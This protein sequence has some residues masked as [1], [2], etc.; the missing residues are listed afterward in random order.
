MLRIYFYKVKK[1]TKSGLLVK[2]W[3]KLQ[4]AEKRIKLL[5]LRELSCKT[6]F[7][8]IIRIS[9]DLSLCHKL[10]FSNPQSL[11]PNVVD[12]INLKL[13]ILLNNYNNISKVYIGLQ[14]FRDRKFI[15]WKRLNS[16]E[17]KKCQDGFSNPNFL[18]VLYEENCL[19]SKRYF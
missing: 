14:W 18:N 8:R 1:D 11:Q 9:L 6:D 13:W 17:Q 2:F 7:S 10:W 5:N 15:L 3:S 19:I 4:L 16:F 12:I